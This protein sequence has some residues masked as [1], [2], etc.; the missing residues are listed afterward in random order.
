MRILFTDREAW[1]DVIRKKFRLTRHQACFGDMTTATLEDYDLI[2]PLTIEDLS[3]LDTVRHRI[4]HNPMPIPRMDSVRLCD[5][6]QKFNQCMNSNGFSDYI[7]R[8]GS[9]LD[10]P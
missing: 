1:T 8:T 2:V 6:K 9:R 7:P 10:Y 4:A 3:F 5:D